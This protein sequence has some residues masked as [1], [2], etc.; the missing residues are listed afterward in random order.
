MFLANKAHQLITLTA[1]KQAEADEL[2]VTL[3]QTLSNVSDHSGT[4][5]NISEDLVTQSKGITALMG[6]ISH[7]TSSIA[8]G[9][10]ELSAAAQQIYASS[11]E[12]GAMLSSIQQ[13][14]DKA[15]TEAEQIDQR[16]DGIFNRAQQSRQTTL[17]LYENIQK[18]V[19][20]AIDEIQAVDKIAGLA[21]QISIWPTKPIC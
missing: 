15:S 19:N 10:E 7:Q 16:A 9:M 13:D 4:T 17:R 5:L 2:T 18:E 11:Q 8:A 6:N 1:T 14:V 20:Q 12:V 21:G 3:R